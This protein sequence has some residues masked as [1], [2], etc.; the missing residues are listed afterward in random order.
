VGTTAVHGN[1]ES[2]EPGKTGG[3]GLTTGPSYRKLKCERLVALPHARRWV[4]SVTSGRPLLISCRSV[5]L[6]A[7]LIASLTQGWSY[8]ANGNRL[9][10]TGNV[11][12]TY[13]VATSS[14]QLDSISGS[15][16]RI[17][18][19]DAAGHTLTYAGNTFTYYNN[20]RIKTA[21]VGSSTTTYVYNALGQR[22]KKSGGS[23]GTVLMFYD[24]AGHILGTT[25]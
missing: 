7:C 2:T 4:S 1:G 25:A 12:G 14:N 3:S 13:T 10:Q 22:I 6:A 24:E 19:Y 11:G 15:P 9:T 18:T 16:N 8:D 23:A 5:K 20:G 17:Y 21:K